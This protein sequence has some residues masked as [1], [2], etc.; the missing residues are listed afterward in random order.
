MK[1]NTM[2]RGSQVAAL[3]CVVVNLMLPS[4]NANA[5]G[6]EKG[7]RVVKNEASRRVDVLVDG[8]PFTSYIWPESL[9]PRRAVVRTRQCQWRRLLEQLNRFAAGTTKEDG[10]NRAPPN[11]PCDWR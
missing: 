4:I 10:H 3:V 5:Q 7:V 11:C 6:S 8:Q 2:G 1:A 9:T